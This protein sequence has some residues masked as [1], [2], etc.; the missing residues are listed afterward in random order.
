M[1]LPCDLTPREWAKLFLG[2]L[3]LAM[4]LWLAIVLALAQ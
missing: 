2:S 3:A 4:I 1:N